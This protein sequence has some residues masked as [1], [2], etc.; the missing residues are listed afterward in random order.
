MAVRIEKIVA[1]VLHEAYERQVQEVM[2]TTPRGAE[3]PV[4]ASPLL[5]SKHR[6]TP[7]TPGNS[8][9]EHEHRGYR[10]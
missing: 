3:G 10:G 6:F 4:R 9:F 2:N 8:T 7:G 1:A 5:F